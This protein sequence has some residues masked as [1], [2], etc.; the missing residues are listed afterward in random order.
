MYVMNPFACSKC[1]VGYRPGELIS[2]QKCGQE[3]CGTCFKQHTH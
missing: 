1:F 2:C 3:F